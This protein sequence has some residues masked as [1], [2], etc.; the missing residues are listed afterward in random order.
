MTSLTTKM[1]VPPLRLWLHNLPRLALA[2][3][4]VLLIR[5]TTKDRVAPQRIPTSP[6]TPRDA[7]VYLYAQADSEGWTTETRQ[8]YAALRYQLGEAAP[9][10]ILNPQ[11]STLVSQQVAAAIHRQDWSTARQSLQNLVALDPT[12]TQ[13]NFQLGL[14]LAIEAP[15]SADVYL[16]VALRDAQLAPIARAVQPLLT[17]AD[18][19]SRCRQLGFVLLSAEQWVFAEYAYS[20]VIDLNSQD[21]LSL[22]Y[23]G[24]IRDQRGGN[25]LS[26][27]ET[28]IGLNPTGAMP[29]YF[30]GLHW[31]LE[32]DYRAAGD[33]FMSAHFLDAAN[34]AITAEIAAT[35]RQLGN[36]DQTAQWL[37]ITVGLDENNIDWLRLRAAFYADTGYLLEEQGMAYIEDAYDRFPDD[38][39]IA[40]SL[41]YAHHRL[42]NSRT[43]L[44]YL[45]FARDA[46]PTDARSQYYYGLVMLKLGN[47]AAAQA[48]FYAAIDSAGSQTG[49]G[50]LADRALSTL[51]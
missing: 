1:R 14:L 33:A 15:V 23:R 25:G 36:N 12:N 50:F 37:D 5:S 40:A 2:L 3:L 38:P 8:T 34:P 44:A 7:L 4:V 48:A 41:G 47:T 11:D 13:V 10:A 20:Q 30:L 29:F 24:Y 6:T 51:S 19:E 27:L 22:T 16:N 32:E 45:E 46:D 43:A 39:S 26:D 31:R 18:T 42:D 21:W 17:V 49:F 35:F 28:A 9:L